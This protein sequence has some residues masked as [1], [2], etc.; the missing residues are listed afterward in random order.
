LTPGNGTYRSKY[1]YARIRIKSG[2]RMDLRGTFTVT[3]EVQ[4]VRYRETVRKMAV[5][6]GLA[7]FVKNRRDGSVKVV[8]E[9]DGNAVR[10]FRRALAI[11]SGRLQV[12]KVESRYSA[13]KGRFTR[14]RICRGKGISDGELEILERLDMGLVIMER[15]DQKHDETNRSIRSMDRHITGMDRHITGMDRN[16][17][18]RFDRMDRKY[19][20]FGRTLKTV[21]KDMKGLKRSSESMASDIRGLRRA[22]GPFRPPAHPKR[23]KAPA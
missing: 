10:A 3:G 5:G 11:R 23:R 20:S 4:G 6:R 8:V 12:E 2:E 21:S 18:R 14:F 16:I 15:S 17:G 13:P 19:D 9:G 7:G 22:A 1:L